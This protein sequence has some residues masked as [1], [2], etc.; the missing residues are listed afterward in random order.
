MTLQII[1]YG[2]MALQRPVA[3][4]LPVTNVTSLTVE[5]FSPICW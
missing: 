3:D 2:F 4:E 5:A 1:V